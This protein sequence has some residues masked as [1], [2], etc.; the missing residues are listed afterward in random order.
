LLIRYGAD[1]DALTVRL[2]TPLYLAVSRGHPEVV[3]LLL[4]YRARLDIR[5]K[6]GMTPLQQAENSNKWEFFMLNKQYLSEACPYLLISH[7]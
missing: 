7:G 4:K 2:G 1:P 6:N 3:A 5:D